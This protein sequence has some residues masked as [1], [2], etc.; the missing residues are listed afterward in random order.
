MVAATIRRRVGGIAPFDPWRHLGPVSALMERAFGQEL[1]PG[2]RYVLRQ[3]RFLGR[4]GAP[5]VWLLGVDPSA[6]SGF[7]WLDGDQVLGNVSL[8]RAASPG[9]W[10]IGNVA[11]DEDWQG[12]GIGRA[13]M[14]AALGA[15]AE[16]GG[17]WVGLEVRQDHPAAL[18]LYQSLGFEPVGTLTELS[19]PAG[20][21]EPPSVSC[22][23]LGL[24]QAA[25][26]HALYDLACAGLERPLQELLELRASLYRTDWETRLGAWVEGTRTGW[27]VVR[28]GGRIVAALRLTSR[29]PARW[30]EVEALAQPDRL[31]EWGPRLVAAAQARLARRRPWEATTALPG[32]REGLEPFFAAAGFR[33]LRRLVQMRRPLGQPPGGAL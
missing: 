1:G 14:E 30:H 5:A 28:E 16:Q 26:A 3:M 10:M 7:V 32:P 17:Q 25:D 4:W 22:P 13:L 19:R 6:M 20:R 12:R 21:F 9:G 18:H 29:W 23:D 2:A 33:R 8:R 15:A 27:W 24:A 11:V 31:E